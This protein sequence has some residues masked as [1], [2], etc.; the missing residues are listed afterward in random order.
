MEAL[1]DSQALWIALAGAVVSV[2]GA[3]IAGHAATSARSQAEAARRQNEI[4]LHSHRLAI[5]EAFLKLR[6][7]VNG[8]VEITGQVLFEY[9]RHA[10]MAE[11]YFPQ[12]VHQALDTVVKDALKIRQVAEDISNP[13]FLSEEEVKKRRLERHERMMLLANSLD[14]ID[15]DLRSALRVVA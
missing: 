4:S 11:F 1:S 7:E 10:K 6:H 8:G 12:S 3:V 13:G 14:T 2:A 5:Y 15:R 9:W